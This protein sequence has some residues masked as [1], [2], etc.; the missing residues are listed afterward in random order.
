MIKK[1]KI[2]SS[3]VNSESNL[4]VV[5]TF[6]IIQDALTELCGVLKIDGPTMKREYNAFW[7]FT[8]TRVKI[9]KKLAWNENVKLTA[10]ISKI[11]LAKMYMDVQVKNTLGEVAFYSRTELCALDIKA[12]K[13]CKLSSVGVSESMVGKNKGMEINFSKIDAEESEPLCRVQI[14][15]TNIDFCH[16]TN[17]LEYMRLIMNTYSVAEMEARPIREIEINY[18]SQSFENDLIAMCKTKNANRDVL[19][20]KKDSKPVVKCEILF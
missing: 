13:I 19:V 6:Q 2:L 3:M 14:K 9:L 1:Q 20:L 11:T 4:S 10:F 15:Y 17:N 18:I 7:V 8:K 12:E 5:G 16:H